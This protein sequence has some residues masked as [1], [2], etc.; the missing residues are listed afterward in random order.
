M[1]DVFTE[2]ANDYKKKKISKDNYNTL[3]LLYK[4]PKE[5]DHTC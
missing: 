4:W 2:A 1:K 3:L 5:H